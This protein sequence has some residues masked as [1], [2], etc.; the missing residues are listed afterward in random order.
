MICR[1]HTP[2]AQWLNR[3]HRYGRCRIFFCELLPPSLSSEDKRQVTSLYVMPTKPIGLTEHTQIYKQFSYESVLIIVFLHLD[4]LPIRTSKINPMK[5]YPSEI[6]VFCH[7][8][9][10]F[11]SM[12][13]ISVIVF[14]WSSVLAFS[15]SFA[16][17]GGIGLGTTAN[18]PAQK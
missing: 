9:R 18:S 12:V 16:L 14:V 10:R 2:K 6:I 11:T 7:F 1:S 8:V 3:H 15:G 5:T 13:L 4:N 17:T